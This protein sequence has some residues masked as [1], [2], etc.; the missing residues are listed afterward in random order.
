MSYS[1]DGVKP[2]LGEAQSVAVVESKSDTT[3]ISLSNG[4]QKRRGKRTRGDTSAEGA[5]GDKVVSAKACTRRA[6]AELLDCHTPVVM[7]VC[8]NP[9]AHQFIFSSDTPAKCILDKSA[10]AILNA[11]LD[12][13][14]YHD[15]KAKLLT[16]NTLRL[17]ED[18]ISRVGE[19]NALFLEGLR[20]SAD[21]L[22][23]LLEAEMKGCDHPVLYYTL[24]SLYSCDD[25]F[26]DMNITKTLDYYDKA[27]KGTHRSSSP[28][29][30]PILRI[31]LVSW[32]LCYITL[33]RLI[34][35]GYCAI[36]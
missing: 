5:I 26:N 36:V 33:F 8:R 30:L 1:L 19:A 2:L 15:G 10:Q 13:L 4:S 7:E 35:L 12:A 14:F 18:A 9:A 34:D 32:P 29:F 21:D 6:P 16:H 27:I 3:Q 11:C 17:I 22:N 25:R 20:S 24:G 28:A 23:Y 31:P